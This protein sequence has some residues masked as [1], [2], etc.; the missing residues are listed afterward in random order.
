M[1]KCLM[2]YLFVKTPS[3]D[4][5]VD[6]RRLERSDYRLGCMVKYTVAFKLNKKAGERD[7]IRRWIIH[8]NDKD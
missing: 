8:P 2:I 4:E 5:I 3:L 6:S 7:W 1:Y